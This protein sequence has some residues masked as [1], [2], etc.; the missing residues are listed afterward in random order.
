MKA[1][2]RVLL[3][4]GNALH[5]PL[6]DESVHVVATSPPYFSLRSYDGDQAVDW[7][8]VSY[9][10]MP[11]L[12]QITIPAMTAP[13]GLEETP[14]AYVGHM[15]LIWRE[16]WRVL[17]PSGVCW[18]NLGDTFARNP[19]KGV[20]FSGE[21]TKFSNRQAVEGNRDSEIPEGV[22]PKDL[23][24][25]PWR[26][27]F[28]LQADGWWYRR[29]IIWWKPNAMPESIKDRPTSAHEYI[30]LL[31]KAERYFYDNEAIKE[32]LKETSLARLGRAI[33]EDRKDSDGYPG[34]TPHT[35]TRPRPNATAL[36]FGGNKADGYGTRL[37]SGNEW[38]PAPG[39]GA[40]KRSVWSVSTKGYPGTHYAVW[41]EDLVEIMVRAGSS[42]HGCCPKCLAPWQRVIEKET[43]IIPVEERAGRMGHNG[44]PP[45]QS[46]WYW[47]APMVLNEYWQPTC[48][49]S[50]NE[51][52]PTRVLD[53][54]AGSGTTPMVANQ[55][56]R[57]GIGMDLAHT[58]LRDQAKERTGIA[59][60][61][62]F[63]NG[64]RDEPKSST[65]NNDTLP[66]LRAIEEQ[67][68]AS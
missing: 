33:G 57:V 2:E 40:N 64:K 12:P 25:I 32:P 42:E 30:F 60:I 28:A 41:P 61:E 54:F 10:P 22:K 38:N 26:V 62:R 43:K 23:M 44:S 35:I 8:E 56:G 48:E 45:Q 67:G 49:C 9:S 55:L 52:I 65:T 7:P 59:A 34:Q 46:G 37:H 27:V 51:T 50:I 31:T 68:K 6:P 66:L 13:L 1:L 63:Y 19:G 14:E 20:K 58:Y 53:P 39:R 29:D 11:G 5:I 47:K 21:N 18:L 17:H 4:N 15:V 3:V 24:G 16:L 36:R